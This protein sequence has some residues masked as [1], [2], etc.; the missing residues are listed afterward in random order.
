MGK[1]SGCDFLLFVQT[2]RFGSDLSI[3]FGLFGSLQT[4]AMRS[5]VC[6]VGICAAGWLGILH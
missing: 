2:F 1:F 5:Q 4:F 3:Q 6:S